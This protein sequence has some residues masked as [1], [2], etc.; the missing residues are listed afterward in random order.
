V[1]WKL[2]SQLTVQVLGF[3]V[4]LVVARLLVPSEYGLASVALALAAFGTIFSELSLGAALVQK[5]SLSQ[6]EASSLMWFGI[7]LGLGL[8]IAFALLA[9]ALAALM[10]NDHIQ[11]LLVAL[12]PV[13]LISTAGTVPTALLNRRMAFRKLE[14][15]MIAATVISSACS[16]VIAAAGGGAWTLIGQQLSFVSVLT[17]LAWLGAHWKPSLVLSRHDLRRLAPFGLSVVGGRVFSTAG[18]NVDNLLVGRYLGSAALGAYAIAYNILLIPVSRLA[19]PIQEISFPAFAA[20]DDSAAVGRLW[21]RANGALLA[22]VAPIMMALAVEADD[23]VHVLLGVRWDRAAPLLRLLAIGGAFQT[24]IRLTPSALQACARPRLQLAFAAAVATALIAGFVVGLHW[25]VNGVAAGYLSVNALAW[26][27][28]MAIVMRST[29]MDF[30][31]VVRAIGP[32]FAASALMCAA[33]VALRAIAPLSSVAALLVVP[34]A[35]VALFAGF[36]LWRADGLVSDLRLMARSMRSG[37]L[38][39]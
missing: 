13:F 21:L 4:S 36:L 32:V 24:L 30:G 33:M 15:R 22:L 16:V 39:D 8:T 5:R 34:A 12:A 35:G 10:A 38:V 29:Q 3:G 27:I 6:V 7:L 26:P 31:R 20:L 9:P 17:V 11:P 18:A 23:F 14:L 37:P 1:L 2:G 25:G 28:G 19:R